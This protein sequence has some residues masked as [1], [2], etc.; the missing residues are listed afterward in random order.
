MRPG[1][2]FTWIK[3][4]GTRKAY[5]FIFLSWA[6]RAPWQLQET[7]LLFTSDTLAI[8]SPFSRGWDC[9][10]IQATWWWRGLWDLATF[11]KRWR[12]DFWS[13]LCRP[14]ERRRQ[15]GSRFRSRLHLRVALNAWTSNP[16]LHFL[17]YF[18]LHN[19][20]VNPG[21]TDYG[22]WKLRWL[23]RV[24]RPHIHTVEQGQLALNRGTWWLA[25]QP[26]RARSCSFIVTSI[27]TGTA[28]TCNGKVWK[29]RNWVPRVVYYSSAR[30]WG[31]KD[32]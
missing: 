14:F 7:L 17:V 2:C 22:F 12:E 25:T 24:T 19:T 1:S 21:Q 23:V 3:I 32:K 20:Q 5:W 29:K 28:E 27:T 4:L 11:P 10:G 18:V 13:K 15:K 9:T 30:C 8:S 6:P 31:H 26:P 16:V